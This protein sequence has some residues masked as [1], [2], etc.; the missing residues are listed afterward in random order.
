MPTTYAIP[1]GLTVM[2]ATVYTGDGTSTRSITNSGSFKPDFVWV[3]NRSTGDY[4]ILVDSVRGGSNVVY[5]NAT[6]AEAA[7]P[8]YGY[9]SGFNSN[10]FVVSSG[11]S[12][13]NG[14][15]SVNKST[16][17]YVG[18]QWQAGQGSTS[19]NTNGSITSTVS[20][21]TTAGFSIVTYTGTGANATVGHGLGVAPSMVIVKCRTQG[22]GYN[23]AVYHS[24]LGA[25][26]F[27]LLN[28]TNAAATASTVW[29]NTAPT[30]TV[31]SLGNDGAINGSGQTFV[32]YCWTP[33]AGFSQFGSYTGNGSTDGPFVY[34][35]FRPKF[36]LIKRTDTT[37]D[38]VTIDSSRAPYNAVSPYLVVNTSAA[39]N[40]YTGWD[41]VSN[42]IKLRNTDAGINASGGTYIYAA[43]AENPFKYANAR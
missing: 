21:S 8:I 32:A 42:G 43:F 41:I 28:L 27:T 15:D 25:T 20:V 23:W 35:G 2:D 24:A 6:L 11:T 38:W 12:P 39:E 4:H 9:T 16:Q 1:N 19:S 5:S 26:Q 34:L 29:N 7:S 40:T 14:T 22:V 18:W 17:A 36:V 33:I 30:S 31:F 37:S 10:G 13:T 3:K